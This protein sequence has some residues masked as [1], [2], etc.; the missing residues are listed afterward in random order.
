MKK[1]TITISKPTKNR[2]DTLKKHPRQSYEEVIVQLLDNARSEGH[3]A[4]TS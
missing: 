1:T 2:L 3:N 4:A